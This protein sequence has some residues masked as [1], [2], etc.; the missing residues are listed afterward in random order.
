[1]ASDVAVCWR[2]SRVKI[3]VLCFDLGDN[4]AARAIL[5]ARLLE[6][7]AQ[8]EVVG[9]C[10]TEGVWEPA[11]AE[12]I[13]H[14]TLPATKF[15]RF[16]AA[17]PALSKLAD[18][19]LVYASKPRLASA[20]I[21]YL[22]RLAAGKPLLLDIDD[23]EVGFFVRSGF[24][25]TAGRALNL[26]NPAGLPWTWLMERLSG[27]ADGITVASR[28]LQQRFGGT[29]IPH[30]RDTEAWRPGG[31]DPTT[32]R[33]QLAVG[34][35]RLVMFLGT[36]RGYKGVLDLCDAV[37]RLRRPDVVLALVG[38][39]PAGLAA[40][41]IEQRYPGVRLV[42]KIPFADVP[43]Y[44]AAA[45]VVAVPQRDTSDTRGQV[46][47]KI[48]DAMALGRP[49]VSTRVSMIPE[50][51]AGCG[52]LVDP[53]DVAALAQGIAHLVDR[54]E[55]AAALGARARERCVARYSFAAARRDLFPLVERVMAATRR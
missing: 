30:V 52:L 14:R 51:L 11:R 7:L 31:A 15:P 41:E 45:D 37:A 5:L 1:M 2:R 6:P 8:V 36:P 32:V 35:G 28:F 16:A 23:W 19:D 25:G 49:I 29:L 46:P 18:G 39:E 20:G 42:G 27:A 3:S 54:P 33:S 13:P 9:P 38:M 24:W 40:R 12:R 22:K 55:E 34:K 17:V 26:A 10:S 43:R 53:G 48:F 44:L 50:I 21:G 47:A 4:A